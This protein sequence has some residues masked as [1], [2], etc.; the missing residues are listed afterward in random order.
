MMPDFSLQEAPRRVAVAGEILVTYRFRTGSI[1]LA[2]PLEMA[3]KGVRCKI[4]SRRSWWSAWKFRM[5]RRRRPDK[6]AAVR[7]PPGTRLR[8]K[9]VPKEIRRE[10]GV[11][12]TE[13]VNCVQLGAESGCDRDAI[14][15]RNGRHVLLQRFGEGVCFQVLADGSHDQKPDEDPEVPCK[16]S[17][18]DMDSHAAAYL[19]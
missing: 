12:A 17:Q 2:S 8:V 3:A 6:S 11:D 5:D 15:F 19:R 9:S 10:F 7:V 1:G 18:P 13:N 4:G 16:L 14:R